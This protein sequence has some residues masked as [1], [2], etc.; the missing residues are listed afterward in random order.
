MKYKLIL[1]LLSLPGL[2]TGCKPVPELS[3]PCSDFGRFCP[4]QPINELPTGVKPC[5]TK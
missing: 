3:S 4:Q 1:I 5:V 2:I